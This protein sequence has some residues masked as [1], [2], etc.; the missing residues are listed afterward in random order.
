MLMSCSLLRIQLENVRGVVQHNSDVPASN[1]LEPPAR[2]PTDNPRRISQEISAISL[3]QDPDEPESDPFIANSSH[4][5][6]S[7]SDLA[8][9]KSP[10]RPGHQSV[11]PDEGLEQ[12]IDEDLG[13]DLSGASGLSARA[14]Y[15]IRALQRSLIRFANDSLECAASEAGTAEADHNIETEARERTSGASRDQDLN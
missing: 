8:P 4:V 13:G 9:L 12:L 1:L 15:D 6:R 2:N 11:E 7:N 3:R 14:L 10:S 5:N